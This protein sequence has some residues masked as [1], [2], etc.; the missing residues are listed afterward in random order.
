[1]LLQAFAKSKLTQSEFAREHGI[2]VATLHAWQRKRQP[3]EATTA[4]LPAPNLFSGSTGA[5]CIEL[6]SGICLEV[7][8][9]FRMEELDLILKALQAA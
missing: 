2:S 8:A 4:F 6:P 5:Y 3:A 1:M 9:G 7:R